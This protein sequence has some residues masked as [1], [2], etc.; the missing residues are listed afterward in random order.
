MSTAHNKETVAEITYQLNER[1]G[2]STE[3]KYMR[4]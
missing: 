3:V 2:T 1:T 4:G